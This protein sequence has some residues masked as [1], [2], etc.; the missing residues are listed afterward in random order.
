MKIVKYEDSIHIDNSDK[1]KVI[2]YHLG[3][4]DINCA[5]AHLSG[6]YPEEGYAINEICKELV[7][8]VNGEGT[9]NKKNHEPIK[10]KAKDVL[11]IDKGEPFYWDAHCEIIMPCTPAWNPEQYKSIEY[12]LRE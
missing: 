12:N 8:V 5:V 6:R 10:F 4:P 2:E 1:C 7:Y 9:L 3:D 11:L